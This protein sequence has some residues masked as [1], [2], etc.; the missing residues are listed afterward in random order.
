M[1]YYYHEEA[2]SF[3]F[4]RIPKLLCTNERYKGLPTEAKFLYGLLL[5]RMGLSATREQWH[6]PDG[7]VFIYFQQAEAMDI[8]NI[9]SKDKIIKLYRALEVAELIQ[10]KRQGLG[11]P[12][13]LYIGRLTPYPKI[14]TSDSPS[15][16]DE[17]AK[18]QKSDFPTST[19]VE[20]SDPVKSKNLTSKSQKAGT[21][22][23]NT[24]SIDTYSIN[25]SVPEASTTTGTDSGTKVFCREEA[26]NQ[27]AAQIDKQALYEKYPPN[28]ATIDAL[29]ALM[30]DELTIRRATAK[31]GGATIPHADVRA[32]LLTLTTDDVAAVLD[33]MKAHP[34]KM[35]NPR[36]Y[37]LTCLYNAPAVRVSN[38]KA[39]KPEKDESELYKYAYELQR[40]RQRK[41]A[42]QEAAK[43][44]GAQYVQE[45]MKEMEAKEEKATV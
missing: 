30:A 37:M 36:G 4:Y 14:H 28:K 34:P 10:R 29:T 39:E 45:F 7:K 38:F 25:Q 3:T 42:Q 41:K 44:Q 16:K 15:D 32:R 23:Y 22:P 24:E 11:K 35:K 26:E 43:T 6:D 27:V 2:D 31:I 13:K 17:A 5:D 19:E 33:A 18:A 8:L 20:K 9:H 21:L 40:R 12:D 1:N